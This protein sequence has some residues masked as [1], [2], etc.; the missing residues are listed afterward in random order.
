MKYDI[1]GLI[2]S[3]RNLGIMDSSQLKQPQGDDLNLE[4]LIKCVSIGKTAV[5]PVRF[6]Y[7]LF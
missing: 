5:D 1:T 2:C 4:D 3:C 6:I 7:L